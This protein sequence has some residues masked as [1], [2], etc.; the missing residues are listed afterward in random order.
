MSYEE[1][2]HTHMHTHAHTHTRA[3]TRTRP[4]T[5]AHFFYAKRFAKS[6]PKP[7]EVLNSDPRPYTRRASELN[8]KPKL[9]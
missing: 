3:R 7:P 2:T 4:H 1:E 8:P 9:A 6:S 5:H